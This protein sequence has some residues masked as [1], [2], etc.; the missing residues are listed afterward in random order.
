MG[1]DRSVATECSVVNLVDEDTKKGG[2]LLVRILLELWV[3]LNDE[4][5]S[6]GREQTS[7]WPESVRVHLRNLRNS[8]I[9]VSCSN[10][11][12]TSSRS[13]YRTPQLLC[14][15]PRRIETE[16]PPELIVRLVSDWKELQR[17][18]GKT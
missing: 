5:G 18:S 14:D 11:R 15:I 4:R 3:D 8:R 1:N 6:D 7:L 16:G 17:F 13:P 10:R 2:R 9:L 12:R